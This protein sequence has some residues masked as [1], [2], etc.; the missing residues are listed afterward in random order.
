MATAGLWIRC[1]FDLHH[2]AQKSIMHVHWRHIRSWLWRHGNVTGI[3]LEHQGPGPAAAVSAPE[4]PKFTLA[5]SV[6]HSLTSTFMSF[7][8]ASNR[9]KNSHNLD[10]AYWSMMTASAYSNW[11]S[12]YCRYYPLSKVCLLW[13]SKFIFSVFV[14]LNSMNRLMPT[15]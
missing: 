13:R 4:A 2:L 7:W 3:R 15:I 14:T 8:Q 10:V 6:V 5:P 11:L 9:K 1:N 12:A